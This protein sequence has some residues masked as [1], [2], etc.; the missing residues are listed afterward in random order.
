[1]TWHWLPL[2]GFGAIAWGFLV[3]GSKVNGGKASSLINWVCGVAAILAALI[4]GRFATNT[5]IQDVVAG[6]AGWGVFFHLV[7]M[8]AVLGALIWTA[9]ILMW[10][11]WSAV[12]ASVPIVLVL[13]AV[14][15][16]LDAGVVSGPFGVF[17]DSKVTALTNEVMDLRTGGTTVGEWF[18]P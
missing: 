9:L 15:S 12:A 1:M 13:L 16:A 14:P 17:L 8:G 3:I 10:D 11:K 18:T 7:L 5:K 2:I 4:A 6:V